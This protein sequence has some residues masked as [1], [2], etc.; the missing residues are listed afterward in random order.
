MSKKKADFVLEN[1][2]IESVA[3]EGK[4]V[5]HVDG[6]VLF[7]EFAVPGDVVDVKVFKKKKNYMEGF[8]LNLVSPSPHRLEPFCP[9][10]GVCGGCK[11]QPLPYSMQLEA[12]RQQVYDQLVR[13]GHL[14]VPEILPTLPSPKT[15]YYRNKLEFTASDKRWLYKDEDPETISPEDRIGLGFHVGKFFDKVLDIKDCHLQSEPSNAIRLF[16]KDF[17]IKNGLEFYNIRGNFGFFRSMF[18]RTT[19]RGEVM[20]ILCFNYDDKKK[21]EAI[22]DAVSERFPEIVSLYYV[23]NSKLNDSIADQSCILY[24]GSEVIYEEMEGLRFRIG[25]KSFYQTNS[26]QAERLYSVARDFAALKGDEI[27]YDLYTGTGTI[28]QFIAARARKV[29][30]IEYV[31]EAIADARVNAEANGIN[32]CVFYAGDMKDVLSP[33]FIEENGRPDVIILDPPR[34]GIHPDVAKVILDAAPDRMVYVSCNPASQ[35][36]DLAIFS[37]KYKITAVQPVDMFPHTQHVEN[38]CALERIV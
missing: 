21:R 5:A 25:P 14:D 18:V 37:E 12:K 33:A 8:V 38:V 1:V 28:A 26:L 22:L 13:I 11:W 3:A 34:A 36:R 32:N 2:T 31:P 20:L 6:Q 23:V 27:V 16:I 35:A 24:K 19:R 29:V 30:G 17:C 7:V 10:F 15:E 4:A 9:H